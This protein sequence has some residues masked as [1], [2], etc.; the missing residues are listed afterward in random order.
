MKHAWNPWTKTTTLKTC[1]FCCGLF[2]GNCIMALDPFSRICLALSSKG[3]KY[4][5]TLAER[6]M[7][8][9]RS[10]IIIGTRKG[11]PNIYMSWSDRLLI[12]MEFVWQKIQ[13]SRKNK[14]Y[15]YKHSVNNYIPSF[16]LYHVY[17]VQLALLQFEQAEKEKRDIK[18]LN[19]LLPQFIWRQ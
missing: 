5:F 10:T 16:V 17:E 19:N 1:S 2:L 14:S 6:Y 3:R 7:F 8:S 12:C 18:Y 4:D 15:N 11:S 13:I 9:K